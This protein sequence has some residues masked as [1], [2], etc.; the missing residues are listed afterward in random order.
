MA[1]YTDKNIN[2]NFYQSAENV[3]FQTYALMVSIKTINE[4]RKKET[5]RCFQTYA[6]MLSIKK[7]ER[8]KR[9]N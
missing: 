3:C 8:K 5:R 7:K 1:V 9:K 4:Q 2:A 6:F